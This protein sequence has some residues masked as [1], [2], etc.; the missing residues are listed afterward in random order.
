[1]LIYLDNANNRKDAPNEN[2]GRELLELF[3]LGEAST[4]GGYTERDIKEAAR[5]LTGYSIE[6][7]TGEFVLRPRIQ[8]TGSKT[9]LGKTGNF[10]GDGLVDVLLAQP[11]T[12]RHIV[13]KLWLEF[14]SPTPKEAV[15]SRIGV[16]FAKSGYDI[17][18]ALRALLLSDDF[19]ASYNRG[20][21]IKS[22]IDLLVGAARQFQF[23][24]SEPQQLLTRAAQLGQNLLM[25][26]N[27]KGW[28]G[29][30]A[31]IN[32]TTL[33]ERKRTTEQ[34]FTQGSG[35][36][37]DTELWLSA[38]GARPDSVP[39]DAAKDKI[40]TAMLALPPAQAVP[41]GTVGSAYI[42]ALTLDPVFQLK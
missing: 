29:G 16:D 17:S 5:A 24:V 2:L 12:A 7:E 21:L 23:A 22:P 8:D 3:S 15:V 39:D 30:T 42:R 35:V 38:Y 33:L 41:A 11:Q 34:I 40:H 32:A 18:V 25:P 20:A 4:G 6:P 26:P 27:V 28:P 31:W 19:W 9:I 36:K 10:D 14:V 37:Y 1:M 13:R